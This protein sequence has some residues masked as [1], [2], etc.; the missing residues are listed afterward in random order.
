MKD[1]LQAFA[2]AATQSGSDCVLVFAKTAMD[3]KLTAYQSTAVGHWNPR[4]WVAR[5]QPHLDEWATVAGICRDEGL[6][7]KVDWDYN[8]K[9]SR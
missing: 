3:A 9:R 2:V 8:K 5:R 7:E 4:N 6:N 1:A